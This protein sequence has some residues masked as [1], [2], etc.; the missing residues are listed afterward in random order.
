MVLVATDGVGIFTGE[1]F[2]LDK[3]VYSNLQ[4]VG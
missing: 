4:I 2:E 1:S 3:S